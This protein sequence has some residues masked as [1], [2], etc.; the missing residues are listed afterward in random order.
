M[1]KQLNE[2]E[3]REYY[4]F[5]IWNIFA[6]LNLGDGWNTTSACESMIVYDSKSWKLKGV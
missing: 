5:K 6:N 2:D 1:N 4:H 3:D